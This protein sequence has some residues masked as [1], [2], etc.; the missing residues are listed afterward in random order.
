MLLRNLSQMCLPDKCD[1]PAAI[2]GTWAIRREPVQSYEIR[3]EMLPL[4][5][6][7]SDLERLHHDGKIVFLDVSLT[8]SVCTLYH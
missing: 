4:N 5:A 3:I 6:A 7:I 1:L 8:M 2:P